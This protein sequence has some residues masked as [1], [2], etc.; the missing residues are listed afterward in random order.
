MEAFVVVI[1][2]YLAGFAFAHAL[3][4]RGHSPVLLYPSAALLGAAVL[5]PAAVAVIARR[6]MDVDAEMID[7]A[8]GSTTSDA[9]ASGDGVHVVLLPPA[10]TRSSGFD[11]LPEALRQR[12]ARTSIVATT[13]HESR[14][15]GLGTGERARATELLREC[16]PFWPLPDRVLAVRS[17]AGID[18]ALDGLG[19]PDV[20]A[21]P[22]G[23]TTR[24]QSR[25]IAE[26][27]E[28]SAHHG[29]PVGV[30][31]P[32]PDQPLPTPHVDLTEVTA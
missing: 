15:A 7:L 9:T 16:G 19:E 21:M 31:P 12:I 25:S 1:L 23:S 13:S 27:F 24:S 20:V 4:R 26:A 29:I 8:D 5:L 28:L 18:V 10:D 22:T 30:L 3:V 17:R 32:T 2:W 11:R 6:S 14:I